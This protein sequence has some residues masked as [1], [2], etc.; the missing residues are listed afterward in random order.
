M[1]CGKTLTAIAILGALYEKGEVRR[2]IVV[3][4]TTV[5]SVWPK[6]LK[7]MAEFPF[8]PAV[9]LGTKARRLK[10]YKE[11]MLLADQSEKDPL[12]LI[13]I[14]YNEIFRDGIR[15]ILREFQAD[16]VI[17]DEGHYIKSHTAQ[18][19]KAAYELGDG[20]KYRLLLTGTPMTNRQDD[21]FGEFRFVDKR[22]FGGNFYQFR[23][24][25]CLMGGF[26]NKVVVGEKNKDEMIRKLHSASLRVTKKDALDLPEET[27]ETRYVEL[28]KNEMDIYEQL[29]KTGLAELDGGEITA[30]LVITKMLRLQQVCGGFAQMDDSESPKPIGTSKLDALKEILMDVVVDGEQKIVVFAR[31]LPE[32]HA[33]CKLVEGMKLGYGVIYGAI[34]QEE[35]GQIVEKF[36]KD[37]ETKVFVAQIATAGLGIT[38]HAAS[39]AVFY[40]KDFSYSNVEQARARIHRIGQK[41]PCTYIDLVAE[42]TIDQ[43]IQRALNDKKDLSQGIC[44]NWREYFL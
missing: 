7:E 4:P 44:D 35:R 38:L 23:N 25:Y 36:Q 19:S 40:S 26:Q 16:A 41:Y 11:M 9:M 12:R 37:P 28:S 15:E 33:I 13:C 1:G 32:V 39:T 34:P 31:F 6:E 8:V 10:A 21:L 30:P 5:V 24:R 18:T 42:D 2:C 14:N 3:A 43:Q 20:A 17:L 27:F 29:R 22:V